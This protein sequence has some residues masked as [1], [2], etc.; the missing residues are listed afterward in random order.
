MSWFKNPFAAKK[1]D[2]SIYTSSNLPAPVSNDLDQKLAS[3]VTA[4]NNM[5]NSMS[6][7]IGAGIGQ[8]SVVESKIE[9]AVTQLK[10]PASVKAALGVPNITD[11]QLA[12][13]S[14]PMIK[15]MGTTKEKKLNSN[16][17]L[18]VFTGPVWSS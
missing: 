17:C 4:V 14:K 9:Q 15:K 10:T 1:P 2:A 11:E 5:N 7:L 13:Q 6:A 3:Y 18:G 8:E 12:E 16:I